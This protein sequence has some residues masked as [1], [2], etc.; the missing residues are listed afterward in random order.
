MLSSSPIPQELVPEN[1]P[2]PLAGTVAACASRTLDALEERGHLKRN[3]R[4]HI[5][6]I[7]LEGISEGKPSEVFET[8]TRLSTVAPRDIPDFISGLGLA[9]AKTLRHRVPLVP[10]LTRLVPPSAFY[11]D[12]PEL[13]IAA[14]ALLVPVLYSED[15]E[16][17]GLG[18]VNPIPAL[19]MAGMVERELPV[20]TGTAP[21]VSVVRLDYDTWRTLLEK[22]FGL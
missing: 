9:V 14:R 8:I 15:H 1:S 20:E 11:T 21:F 13:A 2:N 3:E 18:S 7:H 19:E 4:E 6:G 5:E 22:H 16:A 12:F 17:V 10:N